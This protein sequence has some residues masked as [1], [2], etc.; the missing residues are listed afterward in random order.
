MNKTTFLL[1]IFIISSLYA[2]SAHNNKKTYE[3]IQA[4]KKYKCNLKT[5]TFEYEECIER[6]PENYDEYER[7][8]KILIEDK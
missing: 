7:K 1:T 8:R 4:Y 6:V 5:N 3:N 2:C